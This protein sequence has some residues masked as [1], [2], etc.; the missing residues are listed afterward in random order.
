MRQIELPALPEDA[1]LVSA[2]AAMHAHQ[3]LAVVTVGRNGEVRLVRA[4]Q[5]QR[6]MK[7]GVAT[8]GEVADAI[9]VETA[10]IAPRCDVQ[11]GVK[12][13]TTEEQILGGQVDPNMIDAR[14]GNALACDYALGSLSIGS[15]VIV[16]AQELL[17][18]ALEG[19]PGACYCTDP[20]WQHRA[21]P[22][23]RVC[24]YGDNARVECT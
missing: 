23:D 19:A 6:A 24:P 14:F 13:Y 7:S 18:F 12:W 22:T 1:T 2:L 5:L 17:S 3:R 9:D 10:V 11:F 20:R 21:S 15:A 4:L 8:L 16:T